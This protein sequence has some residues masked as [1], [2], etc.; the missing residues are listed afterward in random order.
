MNDFGSPPRG[1]DR[2]TTNKALRLFRWLALVSLLVA[3]ALAEAEAA[4]FAFVVDTSGSMV[5]YY[6]RRDP[7][8]SL[9]EEFLQSLIYET[10]R[11]GD[12]VVMIT[13]ASRVFDRPGEIVALDGAEPKTVLQEM[14]RLQLKPQEGYG[15]VRSAALGRAV[16]ALQQ[17][18]PGPA[19]IFVVTDR[20]EDAVPTDDSL[21]D[22]EYAKSLQSSK[23]L[24][25]V[26]TIPHGGLVLEVWHLR[27]RGR[28]VAP[29]SIDSALKAVKDLLERIIPGR[30]LTSG[31]VALD[32][33]QG[34]LQI[35]P[36]SRRWRQK[37]A[38]KEL[39][40]ELPVEVQSGYKALHF[41][42]AVQAA[43]AVEVGAGAHT[44]AKTALVFDEAPLEFGPGEKVSGVL[45]VSGLKPL[46]FF[47]LAPLQVK[48]EKGFSAKG[49]LTTEP[50]LFRVQD[51]VSEAKITGAIW[52]AG[53][54]PAVTTSGAIPSPIIIAAP[55][56]WQVFAGIA[57]LVGLVLV[58]LRKWVFSLSLIG[59]GVGAIALSWWSVLGAAIIGGLLGGVLS[60]IIASQP[61]PLDLEYWSN[62]DDLARPIRLERPGSSVSTPAGFVVTRVGSRDNRLEVTAS[63]GRTLLD[64]GGLERSRLELPGQGSFRIR[65]EGGER[66]VNLGPPGLVERPITSG[67]PGYGNASEGG[68]RKT[69][70]DD[71]WGIDN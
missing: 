63:E 36:T 60:Q 20:D 41:R 62:D 64:S 55:R 42:G 65:I 69:R 30:P 11:Q 19:V 31:P 45:R 6:A 9:V 13:F 32:C 35:R 47:A 26:S 59:V 5:A 15:T 29:S 4:G 25:L 51:P 58:L 2:P 50:G 46:G 71:E 34:G 40:Y 17:W 23:A 22:Y 37:H 33:E 43:P 68:D 8:P 18:E 16:R 44:N 1:Y 12:R 14:K 21:Q 61:K 57:V 3:P 53:V 70:P 48:V 56:A 38:G 28:T 10:V 39:Y 54:E 7:K 27:D 67:E 52:M 49:T 24:E 66:L